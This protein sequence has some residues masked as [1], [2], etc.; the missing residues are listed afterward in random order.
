MGR[1]SLG[2]A[3]LSPAERQRRRRE[4]LRAEKA[5]ATAKPTP[6]RRS[7]ATEKPTRNRQPRPPHRPP[8]DAVARRP[9]EPLY[10]AE[11]RRSNA[12]KA[13]AERAGPLHLRAWELYEAISWM[14]A[15]LKRD[16]RP[17]AALP[18]K[19]M[20]TLDQ[21]AQGE[22]VDEDLLRR[23]VAAAEQLKSKLAFDVLSYFPKAS[24][25]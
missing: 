1:P 7:A 17:V 5:G 12:E 23:V 13:R 22:H 24:D 20:T 25:L 18:E 19:A 14:S 21:A 6:R 10:L 16:G 9:S 15:T 4:R 11:I 3:A 8:P 2:G